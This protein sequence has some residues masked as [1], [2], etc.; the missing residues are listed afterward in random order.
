MEQQ[1]QTK[2]LSFSFA[3]V[4]K[5]QE[6][7]PNFDDLKQFSARC[8]T[9]FDAELAKIE[10]FERSM[11]PFNAK[12]EVKTEPKYPSPP[13]P[14]SFHKSNAMSFL[15]DIACRT[16]SNQ[17][18]PIPEERLHN[19]RKKYLQNNNQK[20]TSPLV[21]QNVNSR[22]LYEFIISMP[23]SYP[24]AHHVNLQDELLVE[25]LYKILKVKSN[26]DLMNYKLIKN[27]INYKLKT[28]LRSQLNLRFFPERSIHYQNIFLMPQVLLKEYSQKKEFQ[29]LWRKNSKRNLNRNTSV[30]LNPI[31]IN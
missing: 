18:E 26:G 9:E 6:N 12:E 2:H 7:L 30:S 14:P 20:R 16:L 8:E 3:N 1:H 21:L 31:L 13:K 4:V 5:I 11:K 22:E 28:M 23:N 25:N 24:G 10:Q 29:E 19:L 27:N 15:E 17:F